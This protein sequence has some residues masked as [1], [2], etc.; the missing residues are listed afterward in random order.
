VSPDRAIEILKVTSAGLGVL[1]VA[2]TILLVLLN[3]RKKR[4]EER[5]NQQRS[6][7]EERIQLLELDKEYLRKRIHR[8][9]D[10]V[11]PETGRRIIKEA[12]RSVQVLGINALG[13]LHHS[14]EDLVDLLKRGGRVEI[15]LLD[16]RCS[17]FRDREV[18][19]LDSTGRIRAEWDAS[20]RIMQDI[21][22]QAASHLELRVRT[23]K[24]DRA[25]IIADGWQQDP[26]S[27]V[28]ETC[29]ILVNMY[30]CVEG[31]RGYVGG[32]FLAEQ[33]RLRDHVAISSNL[34]HFRSLW[35]EA[36]LVDLRGSSL[37][38]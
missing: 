1:S 15:L 8:E 9:T 14:R 33:V 25:L 19:E 21:E 13:N 10:H 2:L 34:Q 5:A 3:E 26:N 6:A 27:P 31:K 17:T 32:Q 11:D 28:D 37:A 7:L 29:R 22:K 18:L 38:R 36:A 35:N 23:E 30:P 20:F 12:R 24:P 16:P 4:S